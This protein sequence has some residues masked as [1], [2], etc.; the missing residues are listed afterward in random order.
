[1]NYDKILAALEKRVLDLQ[2]VP[3]VAW[4]NVKFTPTTGQP[5]IQTRFRP[6]G[7]R[8]AFV[9]VGTVGKHLSQRYVGIFQLKLYYPESRGQKPTN[10]IVNEICDK[11]DAGTD[12]SHDGVY[13]TISQTERMRGINESPWFITPVN[14]HWYSYAK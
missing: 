3:S 7:R 2:G 6:S 9:G 14:V 10:T 11:F 12:L 5:Y 4:E 1:M 13:V 8:S